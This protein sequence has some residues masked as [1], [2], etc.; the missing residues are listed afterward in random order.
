MRL[1]DNKRIFWDVDIKDIDSNRAASFI[2]ER[3]FNKGDVEDIRACRRYYGD[4]KIV[5][6]LLKA[7]HISINRLF[8]VSAIFDKQLSDFKCYTSKQL[9][10]QHYPY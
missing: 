1:F 10:P 5:A 2:I 8:L 4:K 6:I 7:K 3:I 9:N